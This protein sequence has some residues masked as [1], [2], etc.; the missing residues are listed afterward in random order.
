MSWA[1]GVFCFKC[2]SVGGL[3]ESLLKTC[4][5]LGSSPEILVEKT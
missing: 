4:V 1:L 2:Q 5:V 3:D